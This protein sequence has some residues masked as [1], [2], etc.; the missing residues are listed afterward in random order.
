MKSTFLNEIGTR[1]ELAKFIDRAKK[2]SMGE[3]CAKFEQDFATFQG[4]EEGVLFNSG[5]SANLAMLQSLKN[6][7][8]LK[9]GDKV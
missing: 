1:E 8:R 5:G 9:D 7:G 6:L 2:L 3:Q 4:A